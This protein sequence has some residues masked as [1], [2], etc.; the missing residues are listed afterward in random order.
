MA[1]AGTVVVSWM[2]F[3]TR[4]FVVLKMISGISALPPLSTT[5]SRQMIIGNYL[6]TVKTL[7]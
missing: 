6:Q 3:I 7:P 5:S 1:K 2:S 4:G